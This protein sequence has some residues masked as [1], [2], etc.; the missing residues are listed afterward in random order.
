MEC[1][2]QVGDMVVCVTNMTLC[3]APPPH[4]A[5]G[6]IYTVS[7]FCTK[8]HRGGLVGLFFDEIQGTGGKG[9]DGITYCPCF[10][11]KDYRPVRKTNIEALRALV[12]TPKV[13]S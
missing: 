11:P 12:L 1:K 2:F 9:S 7:G 10:D 3:A 5:K 4:P 13:T 6:T 8:P